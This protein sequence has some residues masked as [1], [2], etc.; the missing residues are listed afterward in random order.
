MFLHVTK[1]KYCLEL[2]FNNNTTGTVDLKEELWGEIFEPLND[3][4]L[5]R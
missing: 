5:N 3:R 1:V 4:F 2:T